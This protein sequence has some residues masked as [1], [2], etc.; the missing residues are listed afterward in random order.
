MN[1]EGAVYTL[2]KT[3]QKYY[4]YDTNINTIRE[5][6]YETY[7]ILHKMLKNKNIIPNDEI[8]E[9]FNLGFLHPFSVKILEHPQTENIEVQL[10]RNLQRLILQVTQKCNLRCNYCPYSQKNNLNRKHDNRTMSLPIAKKSIDF[11]YNHSLDSESVELNFYGGEPLLNFDLIKDS[12]LYFDNLFYGKNRIY[13]F[14]TNG[15]IFNKNILDFLDKYNFHITISLDGPEY[16]H[17]SN[18][19]FHKSNQGTFFIVF[20]NIQFIHR[21]YPKLFKNMQINTVMDPKNDYQSYQRLLTD[22]TLLS[23]V[24]FSTT[25][26][27]DAFL[28][29]KNIYNSEFN[30]QREYFSF[31]TFLHLSELLD[32]S[33]ELKL[34]KS[35]QE[36]L[37]NLENMLNFHNVLSEKSVPA[38]PCLAGQLRL[39]VNVNGKLLPC[40]KISE[41]V[42][43]NY[44]GDIKNGFIFEHIKKI[45][46]ISQNTEDLCKNCFA[47]RFCGICINSCIHGLND[48]NNKII[49]CKQRKNQILNQLIE[50][51]FIN[52]IKRRNEK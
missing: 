28:D 38:G 41:S 18:R 51:T 39:T 37:L 2:F 49:V 40:E 12:T 52:E 46:N 35:Y 1:F 11:F 3:I 42:D 45:I 33:S 19:K 23:S 4:I 29:N 36:I 6:S 26:I 34:L 24:N 32:L 43:D 14:T 27:E 22:Y 47:F 16:I 25:I 7:L 31:L 30:L 44:I 5:V 48:I 8:I 15:T 9:L 13:G 17:D 10:G 20:E 50:I 21:F